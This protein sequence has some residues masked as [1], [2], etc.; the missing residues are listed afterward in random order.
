MLQ[1]LVDEGHGDEDNGALVKVIEK[2]AGVKVRR[3]TGY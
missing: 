2:L 1:Q 3:P